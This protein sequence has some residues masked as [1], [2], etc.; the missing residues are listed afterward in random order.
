MIVA[1]ATVVATAAAMA[2]TI[3]NFFIVIFPFGLI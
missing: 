2:V 1:D 3:T